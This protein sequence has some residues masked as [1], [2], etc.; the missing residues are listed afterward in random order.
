MQEVR[1]MS[2][3][4][5]ASVKHMATDSGKNGKNLFVVDDYLW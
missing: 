1:G 4:C 2:V 3:V 5:C